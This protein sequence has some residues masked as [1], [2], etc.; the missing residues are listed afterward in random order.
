MHRYRS[1]DQRS[2]DN[3]SLSSL[4]PNATTIKVPYRPLEHQFSPS[5]NQQLH[6]I[7]TKAVEEA[8]GDMNLREDIENLRTRLNN[9]NMSN[10]TTVEWN[11]KPQNKSRLGQSNYKTVVASFQ[12]S[13][14]QVV[15]A[16]NVHLVQQNSPFFNQNESIGSINRLTNSTAHL[17]QPSSN[18]STTNVRNANDES[19]KI[20][21]NEADFNLSDYVKAIPVLVNSD[22]TGIEDDGTSSISFD[23]LRSSR[24]YDIRSAGADYRVENDEELDD[25]KQFPVEKVDLGKDVEEKRPAAWIFDLRDG[26]STAIVAPPHIKQPS[27]PKI[28]S[29]TEELAQSR[30]G[31]SYYLELLEPSKKDARQRQRPS[32]IDSMYSRWNSHSALNSY[33]LKKQPSTNQGK[34]SPSSNFSIQNASNGTRKSRQMMSPSILDSNGR[35]IS[36][37]NC[38]NTMDNGNNGRRQ[39]PFS[40]LPLSNRS[41]SSS[42]LIGST[43][44]TKYS[45]YGGL[46]KPGTDNKPVP[47]LSYSRAIGPK[48][49]RQL[50]AKSKTPSRYLKMK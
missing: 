42:C 15:D 22:E 21:N 32:S 2:L 39:L 16:Y 41:K 27:P 26:S 28:E 24:T 38:N 8:G 14:P 18:T 40:G 23:S 33:D 9:I 17:Q 10:K 13:G 46:R 48:S 5:T 12:Q 3:I 45:I 49:Q 36:S 11:H 35:Q 37:F 1:D 50:D 20:N 44:P 19:T 6:A 30:G 4:G 47:R 43:R 25:E 29:K 7:E 34:P 31:R